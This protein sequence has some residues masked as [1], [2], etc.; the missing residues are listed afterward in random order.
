[1]QRGKIELRQIAIPQKCHFPRMAHFVFKCPDTSSN[2]QHWTDDDD[3]PDDSYE[4]V[5]CPAC[6]KL[7]LINRKTG[8][9]L[10]EK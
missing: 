9:L 7:H 3:A 8:K 6:A 4:A 1:M 2:V 5:T 10:G